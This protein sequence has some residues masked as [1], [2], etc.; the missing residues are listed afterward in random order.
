MAATGIA[1]IT[2]N[3][4]LKGRSAIGGGKTVKSEYLLRLKIEVKK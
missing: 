4:L 3:C 2:K 1:I